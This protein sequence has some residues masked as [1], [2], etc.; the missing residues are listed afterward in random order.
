MTES[1]DTPVQPSSPAE[2]QAVPEP[3]LSESAAPAAN[4]AARKGDLVGI[5]YA[6]RKYVVGFGTKV[7]FSL[8]AFGLLAF[9]V[10]YQ[11][12]KRLTYKNL[13]VDSVVNPTPLEVQDAPDFVLPMG[14]GGKG[15]QLSQMK[16][17]WVFLNFWASWCG[18]CRDEMPSMEMLNRRFKGRMKMVAVSV[19]EDW[20]EVNRFFGD[21]KPTF[22][23]LWD[24]SK[25]TTFRYGT[26][27]FPETY[28]ISPEGKVV[29]KFVGPRD[30]YNQAAVQYFDDL[31]AGRREAAL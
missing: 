30:W 7:A 17:E 3:S 4:P 26:R 16:G 6:E 12:D 22:D 24:R 31:L 1:N 13:L 28:L 5:M 23:V 15:M 9:L 19:D 2:A 18:P 27:K 11:V 29:A 10:V 14:E 21:T 20:R 8:A 25:A